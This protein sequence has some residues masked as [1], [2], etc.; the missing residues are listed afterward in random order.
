MESM[1]LLEAA[2]A[3]AELAFRLLLRR[4]LGQHRRRQRE[5]VRSTSLIYAEAA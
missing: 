4:E 5:E 3:L 2:V 1:A